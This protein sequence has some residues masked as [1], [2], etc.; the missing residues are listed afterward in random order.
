MPVTFAVFTTVAAFVPL[1][2]VTGMIGKIMGVIPL[3]VIPTLLFSLVESLFILPGHLSHYH[4]R[5]KEPW[6]IV[7]RLWKRYQGRFADGVEWFIGNVYKPSLAIALEWRYATVAV[8]VATLLITAGLALGGHLRFVFFPA[9]EAD[10]I[11]A[12]LTMPQGTPA[13]VTRQ[14]VA[15]LVASAQRIEKEV[16]E[17]NGPVFG[18]IMAAVGEQPY[19][20]SQNRNAGGVRASAVGGHLGEVTIELEPAENRSI[21]SEE[22]ATRWRRETGAIPDAEVL[23]FSSAL[24]DLGD[25]IE[26]QF[27]GNDIGELT[28][29]ARELKQV[30]AGYAGVYD[31]AD[32]F[33]E[34]KQ[35]IKLDIKPAAEIYGLR[36]DDVARQVRQAFYGEEAQRVQRGRDDIK[37]MV[38]Y[39]EDERRSLGDLEN[40]RIRTPEGLEV[41]FAEV[42]NAEIGR[43][44]ASIK[45][46]NRRR[47]INV[48]AQVDDT[49]GNAGQIIAALGAETL[50]E[51]AARNPGVFYAFEGQEAER[52]DSMAGLKRGFIVALFAIFALLAIPLRSYVQPILI[53]SAIPFGLVGALWGHMIMGLNLTILSMFGLVALTG[54]V[55]ND[56][57]VMVDFVNRKRREGLDF[58]VAA[59]EA[60]VAR[61][62]P[63]LLT[64]LTTFFGLT[65]LIL[66]KSMQARFLI[67]MA[68]S[69]AFGVVF[70]TFITL[71]LIP[72]GYVIL[73]D[74][75]ALVHRIRGR[76]EADAVQERAA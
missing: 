59:R 69:L 34:G 30:L 25:D 19:N 74:V 17:H 22:L 15:R 31:I 45:R 57:L 65:P 21:G 42:A 13:E 32:S 46:V 14:A 63:I 40:M 23:A 2:G 1:L 75:R 50:P 8:G 56:S 76:K 43:G 29:A 62:R 37:V 16:E 66:E 68:I 27:T 47:A 20:E 49:Q 36:L 3:I 7:S 10:Y 41:P 72:C 52:R 18:H 4:H 5:K 9:V 24:F 64:S 51:I 67:P 61:F 54:V 44:Y 53:M 55:V 39:P 73:E 48:T 35:E 11:S 60:G 28:R 26:V 70:A 71:V 38:R 12:A 6:I 58:E 33:R